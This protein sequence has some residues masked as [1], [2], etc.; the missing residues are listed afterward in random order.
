M[1]VLTRHDPA[2]YAKHGGP[3]SYRKHGRDT[4]AGEC[5]FGSQIM[6]RRGEWIDCPVRDEHNLSDVGGCYVHGNVGVW[7]NPC[8]RLV[9]M[10]MKSHGVW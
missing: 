3:P 2:C 8:E 5:G 7:P 6:T 9:M 10:W 1:S 4:A